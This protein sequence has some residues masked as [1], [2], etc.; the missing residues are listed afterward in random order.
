M[1]NNNYKLALVGISHRTSAIDER[2]RFVI[3]RKEIPDALKGISSYEGV[4]SVVILSTCNRF[5]IYLLVE[6]KINPFNLIG[7]F[8][9]EKYNIDIYDSRK[10]FY[11]KQD[12]DVIEHL[13]RVIS[14]LDSLVL[15][16]YQIQGQVKDAYSLSCQYKTV[17][18]IMHKLFH[19]AFRAGK[20]VRTET[21]FGKAQQSVS[22]S[23][24][25]ILTDL[26]DKSST[27][28]L[29]GVNENIKILAEGLLKAGYKNL[30]FIN[31]TYYKAEMLASQY[32]CRAYSLDDLEKVIAQ[33]DALC[34]A[35]G[36]TNYIVKSSLLNKL[37]M[38]DKCPKIIIDLAIP[39]DIEIDDL[40]KKIKY[41]DLG[42]IQKI[43]EKQKSE[44]EA[45]IP[46][47]EKIIKDEYDLFKA[48]SNNQ[49]NDILTPYSEKFELI[50]QQVIQENSPYFTQSDFEKVDKISRQLLHRLQSVFV[51]IL[52]KEDSKSSD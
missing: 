35:T 49:I 8:Y 5:E 4:E 10:F 47:A 42:A 2:E 45:E 50:R 51:K 15:G 30:N 20:K 28:S 7:K 39:R 43:I 9:L 26:L 23:T 3:E 52:L 16:E 29:I 41:Y 18:G 38:L 36:A 22:G 40:D 17:S 37:F 13:F 33:S 21:S 11:V 25:K 31:R 32:N 34:S 27:I 19:S 24:L 1:I 6:A 48:W 46:L 14:G 44:L 12:D